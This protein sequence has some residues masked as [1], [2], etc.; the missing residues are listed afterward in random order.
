MRGGTRHPGGDPRTH[1]RHRHGDV[2]DIG[3]A[4]TEAER[5]GLDLP[6]RP[7]FDIGRAQRVADLQRKRLLRGSVFDAAEITQYA[8]H[9][10]LQRLVDQH[11]V[12]AMDNLPVD[13]GAGT[14]GGAAGG[15]LE[16][17]PERLHRGGLRVTQVVEDL[18]EIRH[19]VGGV[20]AGG[21]H[22]VDTGLLWHVFPHQV[23]H[24]IHGFHAVQRGAA[25]LGRPGGMRRKP[26]KTELGGAIGQR[27]ARRRG[28]AVSRVPVQRE[29]HVVEQ[30]GAYHVH[31]AATAL[32]G[33]CAVE[34]D[35]ARVAGGLQPVANGDRGGRRSGA[36]QIVPAGVPG[37]LVTQGTALRNRVLGDAR[38]G[39]ELAEDGQHRLAAAVGGDEGGGDLGDAGLD[40]ETLAGELLLQQLAAARL[41]VAYFCVLPQRARRVGG[42]LEALVEVVQVVESLGAHR[43]G[44]GHERQ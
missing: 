22:V 41:L 40:G 3:G 6:L 38:Q 21:N 39:V 36:E 15:G 32:L 44:D 5:V 14:L 16:A 37:R 31:L 35:G 43:R 27:R 26:G 11:R 29:V 10:L 4:V 9:H 18:G 28:I 30:P 7:E 20:A 24:V 33:R 12:I 17:L 34:A 19:H 13:A 2:T 25:A 8:V 1:R 23:D 42:N